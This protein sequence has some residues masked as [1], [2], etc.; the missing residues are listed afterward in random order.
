MQ[1]FSFPSVVGR[2]NLSIMPRFVLCAATMAASG[3]I[4]VGHQA[5]G[6][7]VDARA[8]TQTPEISP[9]TTCIDPHAF[10]DAR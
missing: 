9:A 4:D 3:L 7:H 8:M 10:Y 5:A 2:G 1:S 6:P